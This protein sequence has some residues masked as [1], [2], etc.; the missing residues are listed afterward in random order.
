MPIIFFLP[1][2]KNLFEGKQKSMA[3]GLINL[4]IW[5]KPGLNHSGLTR[6]R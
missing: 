3:F 4:F 2:L 6:V 5:E 1:L